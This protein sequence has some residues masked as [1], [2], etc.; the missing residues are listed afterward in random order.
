MIWRSPYFDIAS[1]LFVPHLVTWDSQTGEFTTI[2]G[3]K[4]FET[5]EGAEEAGRFLRK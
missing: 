5:W 4:G 2:E 1:G 3:P